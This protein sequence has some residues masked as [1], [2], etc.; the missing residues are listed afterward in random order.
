MTRRVCSTCKRD[1]PPIPHTGASG[2]AVDRRGRKHCYPCSDE[3]QQTSLMT[4]TRMTGYLSSDE[5]TVT[6]WTG[7]ILMPVTRKV[8]RYG[9]GFGSQRV[10]FRAMDPR[11]G[12]KWHGTSPGGGMVA[13]LRRSK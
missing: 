3:A 2:Y 8:T 13:R 9:V 4:A 11:T 5:K 7:G 1:L 6:T 10:F 12:T